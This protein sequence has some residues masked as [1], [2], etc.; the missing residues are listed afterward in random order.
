[1]NKKELNNGK[2]CLQVGCDVVEVEILKMTAAEVDHQEEP[3]HG[4]SDNSSKYERGDLRRHVPARRILFL[5]EAR[6]L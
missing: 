5:D 2:F 4:A 3:F 6:G 1:M